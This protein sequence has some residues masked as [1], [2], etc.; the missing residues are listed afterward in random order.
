MLLR[1]TFAMVFLAATA[2]VADE[3]LLV[4]AGG[5][6]RAARLVEIDAQGQMHF[7]SGTKTFALPPAEIVRWGKLAEPAHGP[8]LVLADGGLVPAD[9]L[10]MENE[11][12]TGES[13]V[14]GS[15]KMPLESLSAVVFRW[16]SGHAEQDKL[17]DRIA[18][19]KGD[20]D[21]LCLD[22]G[23][24]LAGL[25][26]GLQ[27]DKIALKA[28]RGPTEI[29]TRRIV[30]LV[31]SPALKQKPSRDGVRLWL[32]MSDGSRLGVTRLMADTGHDQGGT[33]SAS[34]Q[35]GTGFASG[36][37]GTG[38]ASGQGGTGSASG[39]SG[40]G[41]GEASGARESDDATLKVLVGGATWHAP[42]KDLVFVQIVGGRA[43]YLSDLQ[44]AEYKHVPY[45]S[46]T[47]PYATDRSVAGGLLRAGGHL[48][49]KGV[50]VHSAARLTY[51][52]D[53]RYRQFAADVAI[54]DATGGEGNAVFR[55]LVDGREKFA[56]GS[57]R[58]GQRPRAIEV[59]V[60]GG[61]RLELV[62]DF[63]QRGDQQDYADW[64]DARLLP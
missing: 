40:A 49:L 59:D 11:H 24:E 8:I 10:A 13:D 33:G 39:S 17:L 51:K 50:G 16:P 34:G 32:G 21:R 56:S 46:M 63:G 55:V 57:V 36:Q 7:R 25:V 29:E 35:G 22:N 45:L 52:L 47:W 41:T 42:A 60:T 19:T 28:D 4:P 38:F 54:D 5:E 20:Q 64:L 58:G 3:P 27:N 2:A 6:P 23:D 30:V 15:L 18:R 1:I 9:N 44:P 48:Y 12:L 53:G 62:V 43:V 31:F 37:G 14:W 61:K 26:E